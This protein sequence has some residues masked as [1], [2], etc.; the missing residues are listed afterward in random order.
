LRALKENRWRNGSELAP[1][2]RRSIRP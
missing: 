2:R 1:R